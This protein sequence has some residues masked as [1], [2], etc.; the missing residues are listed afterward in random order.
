LKKR[1]L[2]EDLGLEKMI[3]LK[4]MLKEQGGSACIGLTLHGIA[5]V[6]FC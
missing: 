3:I 4:M 1:E 5:P 2:Y 6:A